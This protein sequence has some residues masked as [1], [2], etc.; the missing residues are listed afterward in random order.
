MSLR[1]LSECGK[2]RARMTPNTDTFHEVLLS[3]YWLWSDRHPIKLHENK[4]FKSSNVQWSFI[5]K[6][7]NIYKCKSFRDRLQILLEFHTFFNDF[8]HFYY[9]WK[10]WLYYISRRKRSKISDLNL[11]E[12]FIKVKR[13]AKK[14]YVT[15][16]LE[17]IFSNF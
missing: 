6:K 13:K 11:K 8:F 9:P 10:C 12:K 5:D 4:T 16:K 3:Q 1:I 2:M 14:F 7:Q 15:F 17:K